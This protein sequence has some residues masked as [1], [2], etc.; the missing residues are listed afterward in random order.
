MNASPGCVAIYN[1]RV[2]RYVRDFQIALERIELVTPS[3]NTTHDQTTLE[4]AR[5][6]LDILSAHDLKEIFNGAPDLSGLF[7]SSVP[8]Q[9]SDATHRLMVV[10][11][12]TKQWRD[13]SCP[14]KNGEVNTLQ[15]VIESMAVHSRCF[16]RPAGRHRFLQFLNQVK[17][18]TRARLPESEVAVVWANLFCVS[19]AGKTPTRTPTFAAIKVL[20]ASLLRAQ[21]KVVDPDVILFTTGAAYDAYLRD[22]FPDRTEST[23]IE[24]KCL[25]QFRLG[26]TVCYRTSHPRYVAHNRWRSHALDLACRH[27]ASDT[28]LSAFDDR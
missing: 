15:K 22:C 5:S 17:K 3:T 28:A 8:S 1:K 4:L 12:E 16:D 24:P 13:K 21:I 14:F 23:V 25:W 19:D 2:K 9:F 10:G 20:S 6:Y 18:L 26:R 11:M 7:L 27:L